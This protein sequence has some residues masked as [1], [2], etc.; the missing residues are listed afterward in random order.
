MA[1]GYEGAPTDPE[2][3]R[4]YQRDRLGRSD[5]DTLLIELSAVNA[6]NLSVQVAERESHRAKR[7]ATIRRRM[8]ENTPKFVVF[9]GVTYRGEYEKVVGGPFDG[10]DGGRKPPESGCGLRS[11]EDFPSLSR[12]PRPLR[13][14][15]SP[16]ATLLTGWTRLDTVVALSPASHKPDPTERPSASPIPNKEDRRR[17]TPLT[18][19]AYHTKFGGRQTPTE[20]VLHARTRNGPFCTE[21]LPYPAY[22]QCEKC[23]QAADLLVRDGHGVGGHLPM[24]EAVDRRRGGIFGLG[25]G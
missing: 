2:D 15:G 24:L 16:S 1:L 14:V 21:S 10:V 13:R 8:E 19:T 25:H 4:R 9:Y 18:K 23:D 12:R 5:A 3:V 20:G 6:P 7:I 17:P 11:V 22:G